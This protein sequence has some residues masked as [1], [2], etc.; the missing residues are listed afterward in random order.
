MAVDVATLTVRS[1]GRRGTRFRYDSLGWC[2]GLRRAAH[3]R[4]ADESLRTN[5]SRNMVNHGAFGK[6]AAH[7]RTGV[8]AFASYTG[9]V[10]S[11]VR[12]KDA[13][14]TTSF[15]RISLVIID[16]SACSGSVALLADGIGAARRRLA[17]IRDLLLPKHALDERISR[18]SCRA[19]AADHVGIDPTLRVLPAASRTRVHAFV[20]YAS[21]GAGTI[22]IDDTLRSAV[23]RCANVALNALT[24]RAL[25]DHLAERVGSAGR[26]LARIDGSRRRLGSPGYLP[27]ALEG[28]AGEAF[29]ATTDRAVVDHFASR[30]ES[31]NSQTRI[32]TLLVHAGS[33]RLAFRADDAFGSARRGTSD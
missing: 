5:A 18:K 14:R 15:I 21:L 26:G 13:F 30:Q 16:A 33:G 19:G 11:A 22:R 1:A 9:L 29:A 6:L 28:I 23:R 27:A 8:L 20:V 10:G 24:G 12:A 3:E 25:P 17:R 2:C 31:A 4:I 32:G 7:S